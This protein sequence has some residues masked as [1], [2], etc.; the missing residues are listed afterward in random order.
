MLLKII[1][2]IFSKGISALCNFLILLISTHY[3][4]ATGRGEMAILVLGIALVGIIQS[5][6]SGAVITY[7]I[8]RFS[9]KKLVLVATTWNAVLALLLSP[10]LVFFELFPATYLYHLIGLSF[11]VSSIALI[12]STLL[13]KEKIRLQ[14]SLEILKAVSTVLGMGFFIIWKNEPSLDSVV[15][16]LFS[17]YSF[18]LVIA[19][20]YLAPI[21]GEDDS[22]NNDL[23]TVA[24]N[25]LKIGTQ[26]QLNN[27]SQLINYRFCY[28]LI[29]K[30][31]GLAALGIFSV[32][33]SL[34]EMVWIVCKS[35]SNIHYSKTVNVIDKQTHIQLTT[36]LTK[37]SFILTLPILIVLLAIPDSIH[38]RIFGLE[39]NQFQSV[40]LTMAPGIV[41]LAIFTILNHHF[42]GIGRNLINLSGSLLGNLATVVVGILAV[43][44][45]GNYGGG[46]ATSSGYLVMLLFWIW[47]FNQINNLKYNWLIIKPTEIKSIFYLSKFGN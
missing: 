17:A 31:H 16:A 44:T 22:K 42:S 4:G 41:F 13:G 27:I 46:I 1:E 47:K 36:Q 7:L 25:V 15:A 10:I 38:Q 30:T 40:L 33:T 45:L 43:P 26:M 37:L 24:W 28:Y 19:L 20:L 3:L 21:L 23:K 18:T 6:A 29:E 5:I 12:Q 35:V 9:A 2:T 14:N 34:A 8:P 39:F 11:L 32:A